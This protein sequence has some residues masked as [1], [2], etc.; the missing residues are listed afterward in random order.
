MVFDRSETIPISLPSQSH[1][2][3]IQKQEDSSLP[4]PEAKPSEGKWVV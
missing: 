1:P 2:S 4:L 3:P